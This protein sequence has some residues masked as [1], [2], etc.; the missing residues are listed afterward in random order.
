[1]SRLTRTLATVAA[2]AL[3]LSMAADHL[4]EGGEA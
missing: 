1:M 3:T 2:A 4:R